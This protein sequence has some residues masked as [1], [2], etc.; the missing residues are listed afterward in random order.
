[1]VGAAGPLRPLATRLGL[2]LG[3][4]GLPLLWAAGPLGTELLGAFG[5]APHSVVAD[6]GAGGEA[7]AVHVGHDP[8]AEG[9]DLLGAAQPHRRRAGVPAGLWHDAGVE[10][11]EGRVKLRRRGLL[12][13]AAGELDSA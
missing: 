5:A 13:A 2:P 6:A 12:A 9:L 8:K 1:M 10:L 3:T 11:D 4:L 7:F